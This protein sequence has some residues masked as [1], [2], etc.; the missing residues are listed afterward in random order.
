[1]KLATSIA[2]I[3]AVIMTV[4]ANAPSWS[5]LHKTMYEPL[6]YAMLLSIMIAYIF[7]AFTGINKTYKVYK[8]LTVSHLDLA[9]ALLFGGVLVF[10]VNSEVL[11]IE[12]S[13]LVFTGLAIA[14]AYLNLVLQAQTKVMKISALCALGLV[15]VTFPIGLLTDKYDTGTAELIAAIPLGIK[16]FTT[17][18]VKLWK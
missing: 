13:H 9:T 3:L 11:L 8:K 7:K 12:K 4:L 5:Q 1:M 17:K 14:V 18:T 16:L 15:L 2:L 10:G 6:L